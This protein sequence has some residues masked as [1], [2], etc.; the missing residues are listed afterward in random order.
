MSTS[1]SQTPPGTTASTHTSATPPSSGRTDGR[2]ASAALAPTRCST[3]SS[4]SPASATRGRRT[5]RRT[6]SS[7][8]CTAATRG[9]TTLA[10]ATRA[11]RPAPSS[12]TRRG[13]RTRSSRSSRSRQSPARPSGWSAA[14]SRACQSR[15]RAS[16]PSSTSSPSRDEGRPHSRALTWQGP[17]WQRRAQAE[18]AAATG[19]RRPPTGRLALSRGLALFRRG[20]AVGIFRYAVATAAR[21]RTAP[22]ALSPVASRHLVLDLTHHSPGLSL[23]PDRDGTAI[24]HC[25]LYSY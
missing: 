6:T 18:E 24:V 22:C 19:L 12:S 11:W 13:S 25:F 7:S 3:R 8:C 4:P 21:G 15:K 14:P 20:R 5:R 23:C 2:S 9:C 17:A 10:T 1:P 16:T